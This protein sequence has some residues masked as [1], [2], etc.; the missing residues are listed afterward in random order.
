[1]SSALFSSSRSGGGVASGSKSLVEFKAGKMSLK[2]KMVTPDKRK[3]LV[4]L[5]Q[6]DDSI[7]HFCWKERGGSDAIEDDLMIFPDDVEV[8]KVSQ[9]TTGRVYLMKFKSSNKKMFY[10]MQESESDKDEKLW[11]KIADLLNNPPVPGSTT[12]SSASAAGGT[13]RATSNSTAAGLASAFDS[14][15]G[16]MGSDQLQSF[17]GSITE[18]SLQNMLS[19]MMQPGGSNPLLGNRSGSGSSSNSS[20][21]TSRVQST[22]PS[23][24][25]EQTTSSNS[26][27]VPTASV[28]TPSESK[29]AL[30]LDDPAIIAS[31]LGTGDKTVSAATGASSGQKIALSDLQ[32]ILGNLGN[33]PAD[34]AN[35]SE[36]DLAEIISI[37]TMAPILANKS[38]QE[39]LIQYLPDSDVLPKTEQ[40]LKQTLTTPQFKK[41]MSGFGSAL[42]SGQLGP[43]MRQFDLPEE[44]TLAAAQGNLIEFAK[45]ME[46][47]CRAKKMK[48]DTVKE[49]DDTQ[50]DTK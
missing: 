41:A 39:K 19:G 34:Y 22:L 20:N 17:L 7:M 37:D 32:S 15:F 13:D 10:W 6:S 2:G 25:G 33:A 29:A 27:I 38:I 31:S 49:D 14:E 4:Y 35:Q 46:N 5:Y 12:S 28:A 1:M 36:L 24:Q 44:V 16:G 47:H 23:S 26:N 3:G 42:Q 18:Q 21:Q 40:E 9:C 11:R 45:A 8:K 30:S 50:M 43:L 48:K